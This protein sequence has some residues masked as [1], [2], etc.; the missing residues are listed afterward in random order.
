MFPRT[1]PMPPS[2]SP[3]FYDPTVTDPRLLETLE[4][5]ENQGYRNPQET[6][7]LQRVQRLFRI[8]ISQVAGAALSYSNDLGMVPEWWVVRV[9]SRTT[10]NMAQIMQGSNTYAWVYCDPAKAQVIR[11]PGTDEVL[12]INLFDATGLTPTAM[13]GTINA[14]A[15]AGYC[16]TDIC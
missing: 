7:Q 15:I 9:Q 12:T 10:G 5:A 6:Q 14:W 4:P 13:D 2:Q 1:P 3:D 8:V 11:I 16:P